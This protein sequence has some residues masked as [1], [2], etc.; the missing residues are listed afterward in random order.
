MQDFCMGLNSF[1][2]Y[3]NNNLNQTNIVLLFF[4]G[5]DKFQPSPSL[6]QIFLRI[7]GKKLWRM[8]RVNQIILKK[9]W[10]VPKPWI[11]H[12][13]KFIMILSNFSST[14]SENVETKLETTNHSS[15]R[16]IRSILTIRILLTAE[17]IWFSFKMYLHICPGNVGRV[18]PTPKEKSRPE[19]NAP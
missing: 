12:C 11:K 5:R 4:G 10:L 14:K 17:P 1:V 6:S 3:F 16:T 7:I 15:T 8:M 9:F 13:I 19:K 18:Q 2:F